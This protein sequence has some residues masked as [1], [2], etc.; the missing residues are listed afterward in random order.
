M[1]TGQFRSRNKT[2]IPSII[3]LSRFGVYWMG[4]ALS[5]SEWTSARDSVKGAFFRVQWSDLETSPGNF[6]WGTLENSFQF[7][8]DWNAANSVKKF[9]GFQI[10]LMAK[11]NEPVTPNWLY[12]SPYG[13]NEILGMPD[14]LDPVFIQRV[15]NL[16]E[17]TITRFTTYTQAR[18]DAILFVMS[19]EGSTG[20]VGAPDGQSM[21]DATWQAHRRNQWA[22]IRNKLLA[23]PLTQNIAFMMNPGNDGEQYQW[24]LDNLP[25]VCLKSGKPAHFYNYSGSL[26]EQQRY[27]L[28]NT[29]P[30]TFNATHTVNTGMEYRVRGEHESEQDLPWWGLSETQNE[31]SQ[32]FQVL[33]FNNCF[34][35]IASGNLLSNSYAYDLFNRH[36]GARNVQETNVGFSQ[37]RDL[38]DLADRVRFP[39]II[40][41]N[42]TTGETDAQLTTF[43]NNANANND[44]AAAG[45]IITNHIINNLNLSRKNSI[46]AL[47]PDANYITPDNGRTTD[48]YREDYGVNCFAGNYERFIIQYSPN[49]TTVG[50]WRVGLTTGFHGRHARATDTANGLNEMWFTSQLTNDTSYRVVIQVSYHNLGTGTWGLFYYNGSAK[51]QAGS[52]II[53]TNTSAFIDVTFTIND[54]RGGGHIEHATDFSVKRLSGGDITWSLID[55]EKTTINTP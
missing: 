18:R 13:V 34:Y 45:I 32:V 46:A 12:N 54:F 21:S 9:V 5:S 22:M 55:F 36:C 31:F 15:Q 23:S 37:L 20:D 26:E 28:M 52:T 35:S 3:D 11:N 14:V 50:K 47:F 1:P 38:I 40:Y 41:G 25:N 39:V 42:V 24:A 16:W 17:S 43:I 2:V 4:G 53:K 8:W 44:P 33:V 51:V 10:N 19:A 30:I 27:E 6:A 48:G 49:T 29:Y 7:I